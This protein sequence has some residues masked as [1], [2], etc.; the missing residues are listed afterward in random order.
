MVSYVIRRLIQAVLVLIIVSIIIFLM[1][2]LLPGNP[3]LNYINA[4]NIQV[5][6]PSQLHVLEHQFGLDQPLPVQY[7]K[8]VFG[9]FH[10]D[11]GTSL[12]HPGQQIT[13]LLTQRLPVSFYLGFSAFFLSVI[14]GI[15]FGVICAIRRGTW[16]DTF[17]TLLAN[18][19]VTMPA[20]WLGILMIYFFGVRLNWLPVQGYV[21]PL[22]NIWS[23]IK[24][25]TMPVICLSLFSVASTARQTRS[26]MLEVIRQDYIRTARSG[27]LTELLIITRHALKNGLIPIITL[28]GTQVRTIF[29][30]SV[31][32]ETVF[33]IP[34]MG[35]MMMDAIMGRD[36][37]VVQ[38]GCLVL[39]IIVILINLAIDMSYGWI[40]P[41]IRF[42]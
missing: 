32:I 10:G 36:Y 19:G 31:L 42:V 22:Q 12:V 35:R 5:L 25:A 21:S 14:L 16:I 28:L 13:S 1:M 11:L 20:F 34:G 29:G 33:N 7:L 24:Y 18:L 38:G 9:L 4:S 27:G 40:D 8:W 41:R 26:S 39:A 6:T 23:S 37:P 30:G 15:L 2:H 3:M 17:L